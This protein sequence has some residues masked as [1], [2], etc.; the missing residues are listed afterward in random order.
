MFLT[1]SIFNTI[2]NDAPQPWQLG[3]QDSAAPGYTGIVELHDTIFFYL[4][5][6]CVGVFWVLGTTIYYFNKKNSP[7]VHKY[8]NHGKEDVPIQQLKFYKC[9]IKWLGKTI[10]IH[11]PDRRYYTT[12]SKNHLD[13][14]DVNYVKENSA[15]ISRN[16]IEETKNLMS[17]KK[18]NNSFV[19]KTPSDL[20]LIRPK[21]LDIKHS[22][23]TKLKMNA[24]SG[25]YVNIYEKFSSE[26]FFLIGTFVSI[27]RAGKF[28]DINSSSIQKYMN[29]GEIYKY[30]YKFSSK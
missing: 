3:F 7:I 28:L 1:L 16:H 10:Y 12:I 6:I 14:V 24:V 5:V 4:I 30:R 2:Y 29:S 18:E 15:L 23:N 11:I 13:N 17:L 22:E 25:N 21:V 26:G 27:R 9:H 20:E 19:G 8:L